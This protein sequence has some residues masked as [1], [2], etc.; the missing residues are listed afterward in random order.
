MLGIHNLLHGLFYHPP[1][2][3]VVNQ[4]LA[5]QPVL[6]QPAELFTRRAVGPN[7]LPVAAYGTVDDPMCCIDAFVVA[8]KVANT[9]CPVADEARLHLLQHVNV[10]LYLQVA[11]GVVRES[12]M[13]YL[14][15]HTS[16]F[17]LSLTAERIG[18]VMRFPCLLLIDKSFSGQLLAGNQADMLPRL[19]VNGNLGESTQVLSHIKHQNTVLA[20]PLLERIA[21]H[22]FHGFRNL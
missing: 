5:I 18:I 17:L 7:V 15:I 10:T 8:F 11:I 4:C 21:L 3:V 20:Q 12:R 9:L 6:F 13:P 1:G 22:D 19:S 14:Y 16:S 2:I